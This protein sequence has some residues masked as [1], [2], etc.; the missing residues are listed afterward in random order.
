MGHAR[1]LH[2]CACPGKAALPRNAARRGGGR[3]RV[4]AVRRRHDGAHRYEICEDS[5]IDTRRLQR[6]G[7]SGAAE[8]PLSAGGVGRKENSGAGGN[9]VRVCDSEVT[10]KQILRDAKDLLLFVLFVVAYSY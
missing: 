1:H 3:P 4:R 5:S 10:K 8:L 7:T 2:A 9:A 6:R